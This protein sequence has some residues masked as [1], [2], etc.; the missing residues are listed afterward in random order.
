ML[1]KNILSF[2]R[3][4]LVHHLSVIP[5]NCRKIFLHR[6]QQD[7]HHNYGDS[8]PGALQYCEK[9]LQS[10]MNQNEYPTASL[11]RQLAA[12]LYDGFLILALFFLLLGVFVFIKMDSA[13]P[14]SESESVDPRV[15]WLLFLGTIFFFYSCRNF[16]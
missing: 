12:M 2:L 3:T 4:S 9:N 15:V 7:L 11:T 8:E 6:D 5:L 1:V 16:G 14:L 10:V 13:V